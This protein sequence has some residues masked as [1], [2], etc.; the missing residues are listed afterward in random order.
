MKKYVIFIVF[1]C[2]IAAVSHAEER[3]ALLVGIDEYSNDIITPL[4]GAARDARALRDML[5]EYA[6]FPAD[7]IFCLT[8]DGETDDKSTLP[9]LGNIVTKLDYIA[10]K[11]KA[12]DVFLFFFAGH[13]VSVDDQNYLLA[14]ESDI[15]PFLLRKTALSVEE[16]NQ[17]LSKIQS[18]NT[19]LILDACRNNP[20]AG[21]GDEDNLMTNSFVKSVGDIK[22]RATIY[23]CNTGQRAYEWPGKG[24]GFFSLALEEALKGKADENQDGNVTLS[25]VGIYL[26]ERVPD[27]VERELG[28]GRTQIPRID[29]SG[30]PRAGNM[31][32]SW[33]KPEQRETKPVSGASGIT[34]VSRELRTG[35]SQQKTE[36]TENPTQWET[37]GTS[38]ARNQGTDITSQP[39][40]MDQTRERSED[41]FSQLDLELS[42]YD[43]GHQGPLTQQEIAEGWV[44]AAGECY[45][46]DITPEMG[47]QSSLERARRSAIETALGAEIPTR[48]VLIRSVEDF[49]RAF[50]VLNQS[51]IYGKIIEEKEPTWTSDEYI[52]IRLDA[53]SVPLHRA[54]LRARVSQETSQPDPSFNVSLRLNNR[55]FLDGEEMILSITPTQSC[56]ITVFNILSDHTVLIL[57]TYQGPVS[58]RQTFFMPTETERQ[59]GK[60]FR[61]VLPEGRLENTESVIIVA[62]KDNIPFFPG[63]V[64]G[65]HPDMMITGGKSALEILPTYQSRWRR[66]TVGWWAFRWKDERLIYN[67]TK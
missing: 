64:K 56:Y 61:M 45:G 6:R 20:G 2:A 39:L 43:Q 34:T 15:R 59:A 44:D 3:W 62:T 36:P 54:A 14:Y 33:T 51:N 1:L 42:E 52:Q 53:P 35:A 63:E 19:I 38:G 57:D 8:S 29:V 31:V 23:A 40:G 50:N 11:A 47:R 12:G 55:V 27:L 32:L 58:G 66:S 37:G 41:A 7:N 5:V 18:G 48:G 26:A 22:F 67:S 28:G 21:R 46:E 9:N 49:R 17:Y 65:S 24:R 30:D 4:K 13:G 60:S 10:S 16:L 25:E